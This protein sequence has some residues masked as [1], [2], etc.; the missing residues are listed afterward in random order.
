MSQK[1]DNLL[2]FNSKNKKWY[3][4]YDFSG[5][6]KIFHRINNQ[7]L[8]FAPL[9]IHSFNFFKIKRLT[10]SKSMNI[11]YYKI[12]D[13]P[14]GDKI[15]F[16]RLKNG[17]LQKEVAEMIGIDRSTYIKIEN[18]KTVVSF[19]ILKKLSEI[20]KTDVSELMDDYHNFIYYHQREELKK[21]R[22]EKK[23][24]QKQLADI[25]DVGV[26]MVKR[27]ETGH[28]IISKIYY[29]TLFK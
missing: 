25:L 1:S 3:L 13:K 24:T 17:L 27:W 15:R 2:L 18:N 10:Q 8:E 6:L 16:Y 22:S 9:Y 26:Y 29:E 20:L 11:D 23:I 19:D 14:I 21:F 5:R 4:K 7:V 12:E 28:S